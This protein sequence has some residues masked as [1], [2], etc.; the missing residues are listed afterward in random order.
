MAHVFVKIFLLCV[1]LEGNLCQEWATMLPSSVQGVSGSCVRIAC[2]LTLPGRYDLDLDRTCAAIWRRGSRSGRYVFDSSRTREESASLGYL[3]GHLTGNL[4]EKD[5]STILEDVTSNHNDYYYFRLE[6]DNRLKFNFAQTVLLEIQDSAPRP[7]IAPS[8]GEVKE[9]T[10]MALE[11]WAPASCPTLPPSLTWT[12]QL[13]AV[14]Q[15]RVEAEGQRP[16]RVTAVMNF[17]AT[18]QHNNLD[19]TCRAAYRRQP[20]YTELL[21]KRRR[22]LEVLHGPKNT[23]VSYSRPVRAGTWVTL[24]C[25][26]LANPTVSAYAWYKVDAGQ[27]TFLGRSKRYS[28]AATEDSPGFFCWVRNTYG[29]QNS[30][31]V[32]LDAQFPPKDTTVSV[33]PPGVILEGTPLVLLCESRANPPVYNYSWSINGGEDL[34]IGDLL[35]LEAA[36]PS[37]SGEYRC[38][39]KNL[40]GEQTSAGVQLDVQYPPKNTS[41]SARPQ[42]S[43]PDGSAV[44]LR[45]ASVANP[46]AANVTWY[47]LNGGERTLLG[48]GPEMTFNVSKLSQDKF[49][50][51]NVNVHGAQSAQPIAFDVT[52]APEILRRSS[53]CQDVLAQTRCS[54]VSQANPPPSLHW[55]LSGVLVNHSDRRP[56][57]EEAL[58]NA[59][60]RSIIIM[61]RLSGEQFESSLVCFSSNP[62]GF[63]SIAFNMSSPAAQIGVPVLVG[64]AVGVITML[65][66]SL[67]LLLYICRKTK[68]SFP[69]GER[70]A[71]NAADYLVTNESNTSHVNAIYANDLAKEASPDDEYLHYAHVNVVKRKS[72]D[73]DE[74]RG[75]SSVTGEYA[76]IRLRAAG[77]S[78]QKTQA[79]PEEEK[80]AEVPSAQEVA[81]QD[82]AASTESESDVNAL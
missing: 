61:Q 82:V 8:K 72:M 65:I 44:T 6:C 70:R 11:C 36:R 20:G 4:Q 41:V 64:S 5:C 54:C 66:L 2:R 58:D 1:L 46:P 14:S 17:I 71:D 63:D 25:D 73:G 76:E 47:R 79:E 10:A 3:R 51:E 80:V 59:T 12:P 69:A 57:A 74:I 43:L 21:T 60:R 19:V 48:T 68:G 62:L 29:E 35:T 78:D 9:G 28:V 33:V 30:S 40:L 34:E 18:Y 13:G 53:R 42:G 15:A 45:C 26:T 16:A 52:F 56:I 75:L 67:L 27:V 32:T 55:E 7:T 23:S 49:Y 24:T 22:M 77:E 50:C 39:A 38:K 81:G 31:V 37:H